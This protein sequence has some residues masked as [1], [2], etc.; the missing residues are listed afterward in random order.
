MIDFG[1]IRGVVMD[2]DGVLWRGNLILPGVAEGFAF[3][4]KWGIPFVLATNNSSRSPAEYILKL[5]GF[6]IDGVQTSQIVSSGTATVHHLRAH[7]P[8]GT[9]V[10]VLGGDGL[11]GMLVAAG[12]IVSDGD[13][14]GEGDPVRVV[15]AG[16]DFHLNYDKL[17]HTSLLLRDGADFIGTNDDA[18]FPMPD[19]LAPGAGSILAALRTASGREPL[20]MGKPGAAMFEAALAALGTDAPSTLMIGDRLNT[21]IEGAARLGLQTALV[22]TGVSTQAE[23][24]AAPNPPGDV[25]AGLPELLAAWQTPLMR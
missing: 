9:T 15:V 14:A 12:F 8:V 5:A 23:A 16:I 11:K 4:R 6:G 17:K 25:Y 13:S 3:L 1:A 18:T 19:G 22:L 10:H 20:V 24:D 2:M 7:Y 21:D